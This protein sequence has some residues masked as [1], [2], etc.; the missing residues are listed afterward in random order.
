MENYKQYSDIIT[1]TLVI[2]YLFYKLIYNLFTIKSVVRK[3]VEFNIIKEEVE[4]VKN[5]NMV[6]RIRLEDLERINFRVDSEPSNSELDYSDTESESTDSKSSTELELEYL[7]ESIDK[8]DNIIKN[9]ALYT[10]KETI[11]PHNVKLFI[12]ILEQDYSEELEELFNQEFEK[13]KIEHVTRS[14]VNKF[15]YNPNITELMNKQR[16]WVGGEINSKVFYELRSKFEP[17]TC[18]DNIDY[19]V[20]GSDNDEC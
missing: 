11:G 3:E 4:K 1:P 17:I 18:I 19:N 13:F 10:Q 6:L 15:M 12:K 9:L 5:E 7:N 20:S 2:G 8:L 16:M 14:K